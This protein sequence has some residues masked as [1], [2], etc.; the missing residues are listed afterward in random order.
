MM[1]RRMS[2]RAAPRRPGGTVVRGRTVVLAIGAYF[3]GVGAIVHNSV[4]G[5]LPGLWRKVAGLA[6]GAE[7][8]GKK[9]KIQKN[10]KNRENRRTAEDAEDREHLHHHHHHAHDHAASEDGRTVAQK[11]RD[12]S[13]WRTQAAESQ[14]WAAAGGGGGGVTD[15]ERQRA[16]ERGAGS[17][18]DEI[19]TDEMVMG[20]TLMRRALIRHSRGQV[21]EV[22][23]GTGRN[24]DYYNLDRVSVTSVDSSEGMLRIAARKVLAM[25]ESVRDRIS[26]YITGHGAE[27]EFDTSSFDTVVDTF[28]LCSFEDPV[29]A[30]REMKRVCRPGG[31]IL[32]LEHGRSSYDWLNDILDEHAYKHAKRWGCWWNRDIESIL[33]EAGLDVEYATR[34]HFGTTHYVIATVPSDGEPEEGPP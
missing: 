12:L 20:L 33:T 11:N 9:K 28:G 13:D 29:E 30:L 6:V 23:A 5:G 31:K 32:L 7:E 19:G 25:D 24:F 10:Q 34:W 18:D 1:M 21:L 27:L 2:A 3:A 4:D 8:E 14:R 17:Y 16:F 26:C 15:A 22:A